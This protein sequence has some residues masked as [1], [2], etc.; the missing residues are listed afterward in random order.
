MGVPALATAVAV[1]RAEELAAALAPWETVLDETVVRAITA[2]DRLDEV[3]ALV[4][5]AAPGRQLG[6]GGQLTS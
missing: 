5:A 4:E 1:E 2:G 3:L 6:S